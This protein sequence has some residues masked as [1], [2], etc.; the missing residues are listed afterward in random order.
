MKAVLALYGN[1]SIPRGKCP[2]CQNTSFIIKGRFS[3]CGHPV[4]DIEVVGLVR[5]CGG[6]NNRR[7]LPEG[8]KSSIMERRELMEIHEFDA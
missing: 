2:M 6:E 5:E 8:E 3:C 1:V 4:E 7:I